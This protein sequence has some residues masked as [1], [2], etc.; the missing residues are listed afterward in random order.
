[1]SYI[2][3]LHRF[4]P[5]FIVNGEEAIALSLYLLLDNQNKND[6]ISYKI[7]CYFYVNIYSGKFVCVPVLWEKYSIEN[8]PRENKSVKSVESHMFNFKMYGRD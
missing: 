3:F 6:R 7:Q 4:T 1:M 8:P 5:I 2:Y